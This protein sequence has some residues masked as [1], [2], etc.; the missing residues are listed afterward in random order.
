MAIRRRFIPRLLP[1]LIV[2]SA[3]L[4]TAKIDGLWTG[5]SSV[6][7]PVAAADTPAPATPPA[8]AT[9]SA[10][11]APVGN[12]AQAGSPTPGAPPAAPG[13][14]APPAPQAAP[15]AAVSAAPLP[16][17]SQQ[18]II[19]PLGG[20]MAAHGGGFTPAE[21]GILQDLSQRR[22]DLDKRSDDLDHRALLLQALENQVNAK[23]AKLQ[24][25]QGK[26]KVLANEV[27]QNQQQRLGSLVH[28]Y[29]SMKPADAAQI[30][31]QMDMPVLLQL[32]SRMK[33]QKTAPILAAM[34]PVK[35]R[36]ITMA[37]A[38]KASLP[39]DLKALT[40]TN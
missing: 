5:A 7:L 13:A 21:V 15:V 25:L 31:Q 29:E 33:D 22:A 16:R 20:G 19:D 14:A 37:L 36:A 12:Q 18:G 27:D 8:G 10:T 40:T 11:L 9:P 4:L 28:I 32:L 1:S 39:P 17:P 38:D 26:L 34:D 24:D 6:S 3:F 23:I 35:A 2:A 30:L